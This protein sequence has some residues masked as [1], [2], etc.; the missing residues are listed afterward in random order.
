MKKSLQKFRVP[1]GIL[2]GITKAAI[3]QI[4]KANLKVYWD[5]LLKETRI[6]SMKESCKKFL[7]KKPR[8]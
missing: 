8:N 2:E 5:K 3:E 7:K 1:E 4:S 6:K